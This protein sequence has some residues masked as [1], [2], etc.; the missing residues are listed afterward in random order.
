VIDAAGNRGVVATRAWTIRDS[1][2]P[3]LKIDRKVTVS[4]DGAAT[5]GTM[6]CGEPAGCTVT[7]NMAKLRVGGKRFPVTFVVP[8]TV[9][10]GK[11]VPVQIALKGKALKAF[12][13]RGKAKLTGVY[14]EVTAEGGAKAIHK[15]KIKLKR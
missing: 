3:T 2:A 4:R 10:G 7:G 15:S 12:A 8:P 13:A 5:V 9:A 6:S 1:E 11:T 14:L